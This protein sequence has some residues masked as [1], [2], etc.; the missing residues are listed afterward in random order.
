M[1]N[2]KGMLLFMSM[3]VL[4]VMSL[5]LGWHTSSIKAQETKGDQVAEIT[6]Q[7][8]YPPLFQPYA[9]ES[10]RDWEE[11]STPRTATIDLSP[12]KGYFKEGVSFGGLPIDKDTKELEKLKLMIQYTLRFSGLQYLNVLRYDGSFV[13]LTHDKRGVT[14]SSAPLIFVQGDKVIEPLN[15]FGQGGGDSKPVSLVSNIKHYRADVV[16]RPNDPIS[17]S[18]NRSVKIEYELR[19]N[20]AVVTENT[21][22][23]HVKVMTEFVIAPTGKTR[24]AT[25]ITNLSNVPL[26]NFV[27]GGRYDVDLLS[28][29][30]TIPRGDNIMPVKFLGSNLGVSYDSYGVDAK[31]NP[32]ASE[33]HASANFYFDTKDRPDSWSVKQMMPNGQPRD[34]YNPKITGFSDAYSTGQEV[35]NAPSGDIAY[36]K[37]Q[38]ET[39]DVYDTALYVKNKPVDIDQGESTG[40][41]MSFSAKPQGES[42]PMLDLDEENVFYDGVS[43]TVTGTIMDFGTTTKEDIYYSMTGTAGTFKLVKTISP[44]VP[45]TNVEFSFDIPKSDLGSKGNKSVY[46]YTRNSSGKVSNTVE[47]KLTYNSPPEITIADKQEWFM[48][49]S[50]YNLAGKWKDA[51][52]TAV[53]IKY[54]LDD[55]VVKTL[56]RGVANSPVNTLRD[57]TGVIPAS[58]LGDTSHE[59]S[60]WLTDARGMDS[61]PETWTIG[62]H[63]A[64]DV[65]ANL[66]IGKAEILESEEVEFTSTFQNKA[67]APSVWNNVL[68]ETTEAFPANVTVDKTSVKLNGTTIA[69]SDIEFSADRKLKVKLG[70][71]A[72]SAVMNLT[73]NVVSQIAEPPID[74]NIEVKQ[75][76][77]VSGT[78]ADGTTVEASSGALKTFI[79]KPRIADITVLYLEEDS[80]RELTE[81]ASLTGLIGEEVTISAKKIDGYVLSKVVIDEEEQPVVSSEVTV[82]Y[83]ENY[84]VEFYYTGVLEIKSA[85]V[86]F[87]F[88]TVT[89]SYKKIRVDSAEITDDPFVITDNRLGN[90]DWTLK[91][92]LTTPL[93]NKSGKILNEV[94]RYKNDKDEIILRN[95]FLPIVSRKTTNAGDYSISDTW[96]STGDGFKMEVAPGAVN[97]LGSYHAVIQFQ[98]GI[99]P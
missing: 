36:S 7:S 33:S 23:Y 83:G 39:A 78:T 58:V 47:Q 29:S 96:S 69:A 37:E 85:P 11:V 22:D 93:S 32:D 35:L 62:P 30:P 97:E 54:S 70:K 25:K 19:N 6:E 66:T 13:G 99:T 65:S 52:D 48:T 44:Y 34:F 14:A 63:T 98:L 87:D 61:A 56:S 41:V 18:Y 88:G 71:I 49:G 81:E 95:D 4:V 9:L 74:K 28:S 38:N 92:A 3:S 17:P 21:F 68:Y 1:K 43:H 51:D 79:I 57:F 46:V 2:K 86:G 27:L 50:D 60:V 72:P 20:P 80:E 40:Y 59:L 31:G 82:K 42:L 55:G 8:Q 91:A 64:P 10:M 67:L 73:Y 77:K 15:E 16:L 90:Q 75:A 45:G 53:D 26:Q 84:L 12:P 5:V 89:S 24:Y 94:I 76:Y